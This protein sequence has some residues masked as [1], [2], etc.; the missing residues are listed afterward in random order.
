MSTDTT[1]NRK[2]EDTESQ[3]I[4]RFSVSEQPQTMVTAD[5]PDGGFFSHIFTAITSYKDSV[6]IF[7]PF[8]LLPSHMSDYLHVKCR[9]IETGR[10]YSSIVWIDYDKAAESVWLLLEAC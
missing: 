9:T 6:Y 8:N 10:Q 4:L 5:K 3:Q 7:G 2:E 1:Q